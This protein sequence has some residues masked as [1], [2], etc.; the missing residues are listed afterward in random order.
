MAGAN[1]GATSAEDRLDEI[2]RIIATDMVAEVCSAYV[3]RAGD[4]LELFATQGL[5]P[6]AVHATKLCFGEGIIGDI[7]ARARPFALADAQEHPN[8]AYRPETGEKIYLSLMGVPVLRV[9]RVIG[10]IAVQNRA[11]RQYTEEEV[12][13]LQTIAMV[14]A[15]LIGGGELVDK[16]GITARRRTAGTASSI[17]C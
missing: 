13:T 4:Q 12:E 14:L 9:G 1:G 10:V 3:R 16:G 6:S 15:E 2:V 7:A 5:K 17:T 8:F 11:R